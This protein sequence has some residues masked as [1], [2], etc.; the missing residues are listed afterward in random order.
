[1]KA[2]LLIKSS[3]GQYV[4]YVVV[5]LEH[6]KHFTSVYAGT[7]P[8]CVEVAFALKNAGIEREE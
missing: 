2:N 1:M 7:L 6:G 5:E 8:E 4:L 3:Y